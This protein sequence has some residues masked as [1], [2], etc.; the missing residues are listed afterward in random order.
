LVNDGSEERRCGVR[1]VSDVRRGW[2]E[3]WE[4]SVSSTSSMMGFASYEVS[5]VFWVVEDGGVID[6]VVV[7]VSLG[8]SELGLRASRRFTR[9]ARW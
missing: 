8:D 1:S 7:E 4:M 2:R 6:D 9:R 5:L 3:W